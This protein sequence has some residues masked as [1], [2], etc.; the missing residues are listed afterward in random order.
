MLKCEYF[1]T[2]EGALFWW[3][4]DRKGVFLSSLVQLLHWYALSVVTVQ[5]DWNA[6]TVVSLPSVSRPR[7]IYVLLSL[8]VHYDPLYS[9]LLVSL[10]LS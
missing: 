8:W 6:P 3:N 2:T 4:R 10:A 9:L 7:A 5:S 1:G